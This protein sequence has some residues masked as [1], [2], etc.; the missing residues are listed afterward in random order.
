LTSVI[1]ERPAW[2]TTDVRNARRRRRRAERR[3]RKTKLTIHKEIYVKMR[4]EAVKY[5]VAAKRNFYTSKIDSAGF[6]TKQLFNVTN[7]L[8]C[9]TKKS[10]LPS[11]IPPNE[12]PNHFCK[13]FSAK[14]TGLREELDSRHCLPPVFTAYHGPVFEYFSQVTEGDISTLLKSMPNKSCVLD[15]MPTDLVK[16]CG[17]NLV[18]LIT[19]IINESLNSGMVPPQFK[20][21]V[22]VPIL[23][24]QGLDSNTLN[25]FRPVSNLPFISKILEKVVLKQ[26]QQ[27]L[28]DNALLEINQSAYR[29]NHSVETAVL[30]V[31]DGLLS[32]S[33][34][35]LISL[36]ALLDLSAAFDTLDH[37]ILLSRLETTFGIKGIVLKWFTSYVTERF[38]S[39]IVNGS[40]SDPCHLAYG[41]PQ[42]SVLGPVLF[43]MYSQPLSDTI[44][45]HKC[46]FHKYADDTIIYQSCF[47]DNFDLAKASIQECIR[48]VLCWMDSNRLMLNA[49][50]TEAMAVGTAYRV[51]QIH[52]NSFQILDS[53]IPFRNSVK[54]LGVRLDQTLSMSDHISD[55]SRSTFLSL[56]RISCI[57]QYLSEKATTCLVNSI[58]T[59]RLDFC[60]STLSGITNDQLNRLQ[61][62][63]NCAARVIFKKKKYDHITPILKELHWLPLEYRIQFKLAVL[64]YRHFDGTLPPY[65]SRVLSTYQPSRSLRSSSEKLLKIPRTNLKTAGER[66]FCYSAPAVWNSLPNSLRD[67]NTLLQF[68]NHLK[69]HFFRQAYPDSQY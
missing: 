2:L 20:Q 48:D 18:P 54:Y 38:Q 45:K 69:T 32:R 26:L 58:I 41:V 27:H 36:I 39:V 21:A 22:I 59:S 57:R 66:S 68:K 51:N 9:K 34:E 7:E 14:I 67:S 60:N 4:H 23:K 15:P 63:Q 25:N 40:L 3:W 47:P 11:N 44:V 53:D 42:G 61:R 49:E 50:K 64:A 31:M 6:S 37:S 17:D 56:R 33:D 19:T 8:L 24:K 30:S 12:L 16:Q 43:T 28:C 46:T 65:L 55:V 1:A 10:P 62:I 52:D 35:K 29:K 5:V 13:F